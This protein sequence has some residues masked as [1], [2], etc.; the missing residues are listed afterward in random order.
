MTLRTFFVAVGSAALAAALAGCTAPASDSASSAAAESAASPVSL[1]RAADVVVKGSVAVGQAVTV[2]YEPSDYP[3]A[4][5]GVVPY[6]AL[7]IDQPADNERAVAANV[8]IHVEG[9]FPGSPSVLV[10]DQHN[11]VVASTKGIAGTDV[12]KA[13]VVVP[14][15]TNARF[16]LV[17]DD[18]WVRPMPFTVSAQ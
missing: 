14:A 12:A 5:V 8:S 16:L 6:V 7:R 13:D 15:G 10:V 11:D 18:L 3:N 1:D 2:S 4:A 17:R 9:Q